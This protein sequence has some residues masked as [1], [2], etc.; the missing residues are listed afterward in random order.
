[1]SQILAMAKRLQEAEETIANLKKSEEHSAKSPVDSRHST[2][3]DVT[4]DARRTTPLH[5][6][7]IAINHTQAA[8]DE[9]CHR[10]VHPAGDSNKELLP[11][12]LSLDANGKVLFS[13]N[14]KRFDLT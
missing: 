7:E 14:P 12:D 6:L 11:S 8:Y 13:G 3:S 10:R 4:A 5:H 9:S 2:L 1:M